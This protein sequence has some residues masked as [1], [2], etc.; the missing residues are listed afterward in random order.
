VSGE[1]VR[2]GDRLYL[3]VKTREPLHVYVLNLDQTGS[4]YLLFPLP[5]TQAEN[6]LS[7]G[8]AHRLPGDPAWDYDSWEVSSAG[9]RESF[10]VVAARE[11]LDGLEQILARLEPATPAGP[12]EVGAEMLEALRGI[13]KLSRT[14]GTESVRGEAGEIAEALRALTSSPLSREQVA[15]RE[16][17]LDN[18]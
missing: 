18:P 11:P 13:A 2:R 5:E 12:Q 15:V 3:E 7:A 4:A 8:V 16:I 10:I 17:V 1:R 9:G 14:G 6:P